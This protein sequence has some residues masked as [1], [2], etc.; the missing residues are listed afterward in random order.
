MTVNALKTFVKTYSSNIRLYIKGT[1]KVL[2]IVKETI[3]IFKYEV[4]I[5]YE[6]IQ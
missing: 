1:Y 5:S 3:L 4:K 6:T 2:A